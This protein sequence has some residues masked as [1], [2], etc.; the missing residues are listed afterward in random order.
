MAPAESELDGMHLPQVDDVLPIHFAQ[1]R[2]L[3]MCA[4]G[5]GWIFFFWGRGESVPIRRDWLFF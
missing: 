2:L 3:G 1:E 4:L 5:L